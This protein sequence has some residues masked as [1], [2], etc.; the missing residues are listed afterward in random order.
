MT[1]N[2]LIDKI[3]KNMEINPVFTKED[4]EVYER[5]VNRYRDLEKQYSGEIQTTVSYDEVTTF[6]DRK[7]LCYEEVIEHVYEY[8]DD[9]SDEMHFMC[10]ERI[11]HLARTFVEGE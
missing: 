4:R 7:E 2:M 5:F 3:Q 1:T 10:M 9:L 11:E 6:L 8:A